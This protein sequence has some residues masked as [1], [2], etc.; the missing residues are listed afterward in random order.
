MSV[1]RNGSD[2]WEQARLNTPLVE[3]DTVSTDARGRVEIQIDARNFLRLGANSM[4]R[5]VTL[6]DDGIALSLVEGLA[7]LRLAKF[8]RDKE[9]FEIDAPKATMA[10]EQK[11][12]YRIDVSRQGRVQVS[13]RDGGRARIYSET[14]GFALRDGRTAELIYDGANAGDWE[15][16]AANAA[17]P[18]DLWVSEREQYLAQRLRYDT[19]YYDSYVWGAEDLDAYGN[20]VYATDYGWIWRPHAHVISAYHD[21]APYRYGSW[22]G[23]RHTDGPGWARSHGAGR[24]ITMAVGFITTTT[25]PGVRAV[26]IIGD[27]VGGGRRSSR[28]TFPM[29]IT[30]AGIRCTT[31]NAIPNVVIITAIAFVRCARMRSPDFAA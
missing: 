16:I 9:Y 20:W 18:W 15:F 2:D 10:A 11:G 7:S 23:F 6:R 12:L 22:V 30:F 5:I 25:G 3:G 13:A 29:A 27:A 17:D 1:K 4:L 24:R 14:S 8:D 21:W 31:T 26:S 19:Q 28:F